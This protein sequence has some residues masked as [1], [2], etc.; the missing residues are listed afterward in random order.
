MAIIKN[1]VPN[2][3]VAKLREVYHNRKVNGFERES[4]KKFK[5][6]YINKKGKGE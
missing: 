4:W 5:K 2:M 1:P 3:T 6:K